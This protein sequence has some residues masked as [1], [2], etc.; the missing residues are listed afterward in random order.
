MVTRLKTVRADLPSFEVDA[1]GPLPPFG[2]VATPP[3]DL[4]GHAV[5]DIRGFLIADWLLHRL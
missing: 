3:L 1:L 2:P 5:V 4:F